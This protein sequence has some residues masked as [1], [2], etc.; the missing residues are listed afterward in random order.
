MACVHPRQS[1]DSAGTQ[2]QSTLSY[3]PSCAC[4]VEGG[5]RCGVPRVR[6]LGSSW[7]ERT[8]TSRW[9]S[10]RRACRDLSFVLPQSLG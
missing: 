3:T 7:Y 4:M 9:P 8:T 5:D 2:D 10:Q 6:W 1:L